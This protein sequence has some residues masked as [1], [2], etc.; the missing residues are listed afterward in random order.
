MPKNWWKILISVPMIAIVYV[1][2]LL[3]WLE[4]KEMPFVEFAWW[5]YSLSFLMLWGGVI[6][7]MW[8]YVELISK[9]SGV[10]ELNI[11]TSKLVKSGPY[12]YVRNPMAD[13]LILILFGEALYF[14]SLY[15]FL[16]SI[17]IA[18]AIMLYIIY[19]EEYKLANKYGREYVEYKMDVGRF[20]PRIK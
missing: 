4:F 6:L 9:G 19:V 17:L 14:K 10:L 11:P 16:W 12:K 7:L 8:A 5:R 18:A 20:L 13:G 1:P 2:L 3:L 15:I